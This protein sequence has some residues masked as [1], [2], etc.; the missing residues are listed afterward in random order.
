MRFVRVYI[1]FVNCAL[2]VGRPH[3]SFLRFLIVDLPKQ[4]WCH[5]RFRSSKIHKTTTVRSS[6][7]SWID[8]RALLTILGGLWRSDIWLSEVRFGSNTSYRTPYRTRN[9]PLRPHICAAYN[10]KIILGQVPWVT[11]QAKSQFLDRQ[12]DQSEVQWHISIFCRFIIGEYE[13][14]V[15]VKYPQQTYLLCDSKLCV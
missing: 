10:F 3:F 1:N 4:S 7:S 5:L 15:A 8:R 11:S 12:T 2:P 14:F 13:F 6:L 9:N